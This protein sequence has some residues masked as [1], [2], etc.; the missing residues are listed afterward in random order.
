MAQLAGS[1]RFQRAHERPTNPA[2]VCVE[3]AAS[4]ALR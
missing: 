4:P 1:D 3:W 2:L